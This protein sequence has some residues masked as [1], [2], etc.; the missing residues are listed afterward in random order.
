MDS[1]KYTYCLTLIRV[2]E[3]TG[4]NCSH[5]TSTDSD[6]TEVDGSSIDLSNG[7]C[8]VS[9]T[10]TTSFVIQCNDINGATLSFNFVFSADTATGLFAIKIQT[11]QTINIFNSFDFGLLIFFV[12]SLYI[13]YS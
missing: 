12:Y 1:H 7:N 10:S 3:A 5:R 13:F 6:Y 4:Y 11:L 9:E 2:F 8:T